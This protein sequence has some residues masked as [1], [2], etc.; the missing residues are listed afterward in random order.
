MVLLMV[1]Q[2][3]LVLEAFLAFLTVIRFCRAVIL[4]VLQAELR[5]LSTVIAAVHLFTTPSLLVL[6]QYSFSLEVG[7]ADGAVK[8]VHLC[9]LLVPYLT[10]VVLG[11]RCF[12]LNQF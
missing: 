10:G 11:G 5:P 12:G 7:L 4:V 6:L 9:L 2:Q 8:V 3:V 1:F